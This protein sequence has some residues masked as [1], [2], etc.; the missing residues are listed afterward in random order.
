MLQ[1]LSVPQIEQALQ[2]LD[3]PTLEPPPEE[4]RTLNELEWMFLDR[5]LRG[6]QLEKR[7]NPVH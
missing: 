7:A 2:W 6:L 5:M 3:S 4:L 1:N